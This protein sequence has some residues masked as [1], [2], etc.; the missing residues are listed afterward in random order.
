MFG[1]HILIGG[2]CQRVPLF[3]ND[4]NPPRTGDHSCAL[5]SW[6][7]SCPTRKTVLRRHKA[8]CDADEQ[9]QPV[10]CDRLDGG[11]SARAQGP[12]VFGCHPV[13]AR[14][15]DHAAVAGFQQVAT[16]LVGG[17]Y[18]RSRRRL[19]PGHGLRKNQLGR[20]C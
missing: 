10:G 2:L 16:I 12:C 20:H 9:R 4:P 18:Q 1:T 19:L 7:C 11:G 3:F 5:V 6:L 13:T 17:Q 14:P 15:I 8:T